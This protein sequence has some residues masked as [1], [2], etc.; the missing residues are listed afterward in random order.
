MKHLCAALFL[1]LCFAQ[2][3][4]GAQNADLESI[5]RIMSVQESAWNAGDLPAFM[6]GYWHADSLTFIGS[7]GLSYGW[8]TTLD[9]YR[10]SYPSPEAMGKLTFTLLFVEQLSPTSAYVI[11]RWQLARTKDDLSGHFTL[12]WKKIDGNWVIVADHS[13]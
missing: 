4:A 6:A 9:N 13:S 7:R 1:F 8:Q 2:P 12:L 11:G 5:R 3:T 10:K